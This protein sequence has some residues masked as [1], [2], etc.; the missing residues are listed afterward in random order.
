MSLYPFFGPRP[1]LSAMREMMRDMIAMQRHF[2]PM[3]FHGASAAAQNEYDNDKFTVNLAVSEFKPDELKIDV[4]GRQLKIEGNQKI[5]NENGFS[6]RSFSRV[7][8]LPDD[9]DTSAIVSNL[10]NDGRLSIEAPRI[11]KKEGT[12][13]PINVNPAVTEK[14]K[15]EA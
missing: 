13:I 12:S 2:E 10:S 4:N 6:H 3:V 14:A 5:E 1:M 8:L 11:A 7:V 9:V 15:P